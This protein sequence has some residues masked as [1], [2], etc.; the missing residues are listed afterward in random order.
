MLAIDN[1]TF[2][3]LVTHR[4]VLRSLVPEDVEAVFALRSDPVAMHYVPR[5]LAT[6]LDDA[7]AHI[8]NI[9]D[10]Q[11]ANKCLQWAI[12]IRGDPKMVG[13]IGFWRLQK[14]HDRGELGYML[15]PVF[16]GAGIVTEA[17]RAVVAHAFANLNFHSIE[18]VVDPHNPAS[19]K[20]LEKNGFR[21][22][23]WFREN[24]LWN[25]EYLDSVVYGLLKHEHTL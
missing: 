22:E 3:D 19:M 9:L 14:E 6:S 25:G 21:R 1:A 24:F 20:V 7:A 11:R 15:L 23:G 16:W 8:E 18:A 4:L 2:T 17:I 10:E 13:I 5:P 12:T